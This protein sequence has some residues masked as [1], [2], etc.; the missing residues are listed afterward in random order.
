MPQRVVHTASHAGATWNGELTVWIPDAPWK[1]RLL[2]VPSA[3]LLALV[4]GYVALVLL[5]IVMNVRSVAR[6]RGA[7]RPCLR[8][9]AGAIALGAVVVPVSRAWANE[10]IMNSL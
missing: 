1:L 7:L 8:S 2:A 9:A 4:I 6:S 10:K 5:L 3:T